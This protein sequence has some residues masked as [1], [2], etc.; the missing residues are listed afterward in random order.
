MHWSAGSTRGP[1]EIADY[2]C[3]V[4]GGELRA[5]D[6]ATDARWVDTAALADLPLVEKLL[7][8]LTEWDALPRS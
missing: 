4:V 1:Y 8:V 6:D 3:A 5:G 2:L 7:A